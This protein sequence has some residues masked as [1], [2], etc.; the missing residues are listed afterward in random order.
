MFF[1]KITKKCHSCGQNLLILE[2]QLSIYGKISI[3][4]KCEPCGY[5]WEFEETDLTE[6]KIIT[7]FSKFVTID[8]NN[9]DK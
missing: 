5:K 1:A 3:T 8:N 9:I 6:N 7:D 4:Y 2:P